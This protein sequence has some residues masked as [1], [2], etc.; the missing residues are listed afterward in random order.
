MSPPP[1]SAL[2][3]I[4]RCPRLLQVNFGES[5]VPIDWFMGTFVANE[6]EYAARAAAAEARK[7]AG[8]KKT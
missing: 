2:T 7:A 8:K 4:H 6:E 1:R 5:Y 3:T